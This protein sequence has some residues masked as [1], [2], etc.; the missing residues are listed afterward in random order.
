[1]TQFAT[2]VHDN[3]DSIVDFVELLKNKR[4]KKIRLTPERFHVF[5]NSHQKKKECSTNLFLFTERFNISTIQ[6]GLAHHSILIFF[7]SVKTGKM[8]VS[9]GKTSSLDFCR[10]RAFYQMMK[11]K[12]VCA[13]QA[14]HGSYVDNRQGS[15][16]IPRHK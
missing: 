2:S 13:K 14:R 10:A 11:K 9:E 15:H 12:M 3:R 1:M 16:S 5:N 4:E 8:R 6:H 7:P